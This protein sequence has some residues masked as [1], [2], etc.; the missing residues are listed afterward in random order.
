MLGEETMFTSSVSASSSCTNWK[1]R[2]LRRILG[3]LKADAE[4]N[5]RRLED[6]ADFLESPFVKL[7]VLVVGPGIARRGQ[8]RHTA[9]AAG[10]NGR[11]GVFRQL[12]HFLGERFVVAFP[13]ERGRRRCPA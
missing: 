7:E 2:F 3:R 9:R 6:L 10:R 5:A 4:A 11:L 1:A 12:L 13:I 8:R